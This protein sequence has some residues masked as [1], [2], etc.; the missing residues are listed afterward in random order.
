ME[1]EKYNVWMFLFLFSSLLNLAFIGGLSNLTAVSK[2]SGKM[3]V[4]APEMNIS[5]TGSSKHFYFNYSENV[6]A[7][8]LSDIFKIKNLY[9]S[10]GDIILFI[11]FLL[12]IVLDLVLLK[13]YIVYRREKKCLFQKKF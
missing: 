3:P 11:S 8:Y 7:F 13:I 1:I 2:N 9:F 5:E 4:Y 12:T 6:N 10:I